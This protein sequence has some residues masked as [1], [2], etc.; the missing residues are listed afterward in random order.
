MKRSRAV[1]S[2]G[3][4]VGSGCMLRER[5]IEGGL[6]V[7]KGANRDGDH[8]EE[9]AEGEH[10]T[11][12]GG[13]ARQPDVGN[14]INEGDGSALPEEV[15]ESPAESFPVMSHGR[16]LFCSMRV[17]RA[18][19]SWSLTESSESACIASCAAEPAKRR[20]EMSRSS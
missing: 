9:R 13:A 20:S 8:A 14:A 1:S 18:S 15:D 6:F 7:S 4:E 11:R 12:V 16:V 17:R 10:V 19:R 3:A 5:L 2:N